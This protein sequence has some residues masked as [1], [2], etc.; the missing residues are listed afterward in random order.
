MDHHLLLAHALNRTTERDLRVGRTTRPARRGDIA[1][2]R[3]HQRDRGR[4]A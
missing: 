4:T 1:Q 3:A 2:R